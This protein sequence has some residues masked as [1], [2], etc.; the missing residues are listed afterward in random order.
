MSDPEQRG[1]D[2]DNDEVD[3]I[4]PQGQ[5]DQQDYDHV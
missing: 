4:A 3:M 1:Q 2:G 5:D